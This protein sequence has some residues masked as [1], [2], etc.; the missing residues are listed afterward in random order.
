MDVQV[1]GPGHTGDRRKQLRKMGYG[2]PECYA[3]ED[4]VLVTLRTTA[5]FVKTQ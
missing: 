4:G 5:I 2:G 3:E 1:S